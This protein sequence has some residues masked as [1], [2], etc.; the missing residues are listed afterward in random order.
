ML[1]GPDTA[2]GPDVHRMLI[3]HHPTAVDDALLGAG[4]HAVLLELGQEPLD[5]CGRLGA[6]LGELHGLYWL[7]GGRDQP[8]AR[9]RLVHQVEH[10][11]PESERG[12]TDEPEP[13]LT[14]FCVRV[15]L[16]RR[17]HCGRMRLL[18]MRTPALDPTALVRFF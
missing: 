3:T 12:E 6:D 7:A 10:A 2:R 15:E 18:A 14:F 4:E 1:E 17:S 11:L 5:D 9:H 8:P 16:E 13:R